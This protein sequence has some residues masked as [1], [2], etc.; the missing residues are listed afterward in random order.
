[1][2]VQV[3][4]NCQCDCSGNFCSGCGQKVK[5]RRLD[6]NYLIDEF[7]Y[8]VLHL[9]GGL[10]YTAR[11]LFKRPGHA[12]RE[13]VEGRRIQ[14]YK[15]VLLVFVL[16]GV[17]GLLMHYLDYSQFYQNSMQEEQ[18]TKL[19][20]GVTQWIVNHYALFELVNLPMLS[21]CSWLAYKSWGYN[22]I[23][24]FVL[25]AFA[26]AQRLLFTIAIFPIIYLLWYTQTIWGLIIASVL[27]MLSG[28]L[29]LWIYVQFFKG[30]DRGFA[31][32]RFIL[33]IVYFCVVSLLLTLAGA[34][35]Y[36][37]IVGMPA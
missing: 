35:V 26:S 19:S 2:E 29:T 24:H 14:H 33:T 4:K 18:A 3:C 23:E 34:F 25:N 9:N 32:L 30:H 28:L 8:T 36:L 7:K 15:P 20:M 17:N 31:I 21:L 10:F 16:A 1:M 6:W 5:T 27:S 37:S 22:F 12:A 11:Q 13:F